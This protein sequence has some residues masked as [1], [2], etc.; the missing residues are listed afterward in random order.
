MHLLSR[1][2]CRGPRSPIA[3]TGKLLAKWAEKAKDCLVP[4]PKNF[5]AQNPDMRIGGMASSVRK[6]SRVLACLGWTAVHSQLNTVL[7]RQV[8]HCCYIAKPPDVSQES[9]TNK[10]VSRKPCLSTLNLTL[11][12]FHYLLAALGISQ[13]T[14]NCKLRS[15]AS[16][17][18][19]LF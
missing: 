12:T 19:S 8:S 15:N 9:I 4:L 5:E 14:I 11:H 6:L 16:F 17:S 18:L 10:G 2:A 1:Y 7:S 13:N 3:I